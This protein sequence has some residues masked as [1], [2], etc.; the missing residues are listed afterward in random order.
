[1]R[2]FLLLVI[3]FLILSCSKREIVEKKTISRK[4]L[5]VAASIAPYYDFA[6]I[7][8]KDRIEAYLI[9]PSGESPHT[10]N[11]RPSQQKLI[12]Q[13]DI[14]IINGLSLEY[15][16]DKMIDASENRKLI[17]LKSSEGF[18]IITDLSHKHENEAKHEE[19]EHKHGHDSGNPHIWL[20]P[21]YAIVIVDKIQSAFE[22]ADPVNADF[23]K[24][25]AVAYKVNLKE[26]D[27]EIREKAGKWKS[28]DF[29]TFHPSFEYFAREYGLNQA[30]VIEEI[31]GREPTPKELREIIEKAK[32]TKAKALFAEPQF[33]LTI[34]KSIADE[35]GMK[36]AI[37][38]PLPESYLAGMKENL[39]QLEKAL[40]D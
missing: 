38:N 8:G 2:I 40:G 12:S 19:N 3:S 9:I 10:F 32:K 29:I 36:V 5:I 23:Y 25:N 21:C 26:L 27:K 33:P 18:P 4:K 37:L 39:K 30:A 1:M 6:K 28:R 13:A 16:L 20:N 7:I 22:K 34:V 35:A 11:P 24:S 31:P 17:V 14:L 15:W